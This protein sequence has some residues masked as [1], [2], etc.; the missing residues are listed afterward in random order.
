MQWTGPGYL[1]VYEG[2]KL[3]F[4]FVHNYTTSLYDVVLRYEANLHKWRD[5]Y[6]RINDLGFSDRFY[7]VMTSRAHLF[8]EYSESNS[9]HCK[10]H[11]IN[12]RQHSIEESSNYLE[13]CI[14]I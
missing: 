10:Q 14:L 3:K 11:T 9:T 1:Q 4:N 13:K 8:D 5:V 6:V 2:G 7:E 12:K